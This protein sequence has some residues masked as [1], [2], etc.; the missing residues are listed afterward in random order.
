[1]PKSYACSPF[2]ASIDPG[3]IT[4]QWNFTAVVDVH[5]GVPHKQVENYRLICFTFIF[6]WCLEGFAAEYLSTYLK[7]YSLLRKVW[8]EVSE[9][10]LS[11]DLLRVCKWDH[12][13]IGWEECCVGKLFTLQKK[14]L[15]PIIIDHRCIMASLSWSKPPNVLHFWFTDE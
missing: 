8:H 6:C 7:N 1:M 13:V 11:L 4:L 3:K 5:K 15:I 9:N 10:M 2:L 12:R 14:R